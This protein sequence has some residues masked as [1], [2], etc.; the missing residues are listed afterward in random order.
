MFFRCPRCG[1][2]TH[3]ALAATAEITLTQYPDPQG[4]PAYDDYTV[5]QD[6][7]FAWESTTPVTCGVCD[8]KAPAQAFEEAQEQTEDRP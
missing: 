4:R 7:G 3:F 6:S 2:T 1:Q 5:E 8:Y